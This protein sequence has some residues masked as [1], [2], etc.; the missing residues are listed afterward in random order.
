MRWPNPPSLFAHSFVIRH[1]DLAISLYVS[2]IPPRFSQPGQDP[3]LHPGRRY[4]RRA[5]DR[6]EHRRV[7]PGQR[8]PDPSA[9]LQ[10]AGGSCSALRKIQRPG[11]RP[12]SGL[13]PGISR[14]GE[15]GQQLRTHRRIQLRGFQPD[16]RR[17]A[18][19]GPGRPRDTELVSTP[20]RASNQ[21]ARF[22]RQRIRRRQRR[23]G[24]DQRAS[25]AAT[26]QFRSKAR[27]RPGS[28]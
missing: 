13:S 5:R 20:G 9:A 1:A 24:H 16:W 19:A 25:L 7:Q 28:G 6:G 14:L 3:G 11:T 8:A 26:I 2:R 12:D 23:R 27:R 10:G 4:H 18:R 21:R 17:N 22:Q 15:T